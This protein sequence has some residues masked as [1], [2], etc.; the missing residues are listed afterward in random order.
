M[1]CWFRAGAPAFWLRHS[2]AVLLVW[3][4][5][6]GLQAAAFERPARASEAGFSR[7]VE[8]LWP[9]AQAAGV[10]REVFE[11]AVSGLTPEPNVIS[12]PKTQAE[13]T[14]SIPAYVSGAV[15]KG[16]INRGR[17]V[18]VELARQFGAVEARTGVPA[19]VITAILGVESNFGAATGRAD[20]LRVLATLAYKGHMGMK[21][22]DE[23]VAALVMLQKGYATRERLRGSWAGALGQPQFMPSAYLKY[24]ESYAGDA[25]PDIWTSRAD[26]IASIGNFLSK[27]GWNPG[28]PWGLEVE[29]PTNFDFASFDLDFSQWR[30]LGFARAKG[31]ALPASGAASL[32]MPAGA[33]GPAFLLTD[34]FEVIRQ[35]NTSDAYALSVAL[36]SDAIAGRNV[37]PV[38]WPKVAPLSTAEC[39]T[40]QQLLAQRGFYRG[41]VDGKLGRTSRNAVHA[42]Q[43]SQ[44]ISPADGFATKDILAKL[45]AM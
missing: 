12:R 30:A 7:F 42:F 1:R 8:S 29:I 19:E 5:F 15:T 32:Y 28:L 26:S 4:P 31:G 37:P 35:Y 23:F 43:L 34:N 22:A 45:R 33:K 6:W 9:A 36:L 24:A 2:A 18:R 44:G 25:A 17:A 16:R 38:R 27:S 21:L 20:V 14:I 13:F 10:S 41:A 11:N 39:K 3:G 40:M